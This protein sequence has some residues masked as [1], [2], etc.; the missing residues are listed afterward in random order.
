MR[1]LLIFRSEDD[2]DFDRY[3]LAEE[4]M[5]LMDAAELADSII[6]GVK[7]DMGDSYGGWDHAELYLNAAGFESINWIHCDS[8]AEGGDQ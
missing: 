8:I 4:G 7:K 1:T 6:G 3:I 2:R 5:R